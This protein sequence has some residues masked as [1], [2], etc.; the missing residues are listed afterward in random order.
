MPKLP[1]VKENISQDKSTGMDLL[2]R[3]SVA[4]EAAP[5]TDKGTYMGFQSLCRAQHTTRGVSRQP[6]E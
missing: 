2:N 1:R 4:K 6:P 3:T 5:R